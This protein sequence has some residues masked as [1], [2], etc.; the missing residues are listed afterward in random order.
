MHLTV[1][2]TPGVPLQDVTSP[3]HAIRTTPTTDGRYE[4]TLAEDEGN[5]AR[6][7]LHAKD[8]PVRSVVVGI[9]DQVTDEG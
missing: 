2:L 8:A 7:L 4:V 5:R 9:V 6:P 3:Y 1:D